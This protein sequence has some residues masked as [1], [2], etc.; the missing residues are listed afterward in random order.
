[1]WA[2]ISTWQSN[3]DLQGVQVWLQYRP[4]RPALP[5]VPCCHTWADGPPLCH[6]PGLPLVLLLLSCTLRAAMF[7]A[8]DEAK[9]AQLTLSKLEAVAQ[10]LRESQEGAAKELVQV[11]KQACWRGCPLPSV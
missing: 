1:M 11:W 8:Q 6:N 5:L 10:K 2:T 3:F 4:L 9:E 7:K